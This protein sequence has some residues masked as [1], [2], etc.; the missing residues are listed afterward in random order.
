MGVR[1]E[2]LGAMLPFDG[3]ALPDSPAALADAIVRGLERYRISAREVRAE[4]G[5]WPSLD[6]LVVDLTGARISQEFRFPS[7]RSFG[8]EQIPIAHV[9]VRG[10]PI[11]FE[12]APL[13]LG[14]SAT[15]AALALSAA[16]GAGSLLTLA[17]VADGQI[18][19]EAQHHDLEALAHQ[20]IAP[21]A[22]QQGVE[23]QSTQVALTS[24]TP[25]SLDFRVE[26]SAKM[27]VMTARATVTGHVEVDDQFNAHLS[28][29]ACK[30]HGLVAGAATAFL[31]PH[32]A[33]LE[34]QPI[35]L[36]ALP[37]GEI[38]LRDVSVAVAG[39]VRLHARFGA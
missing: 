24:D 9:E 8:T 39:A 12:T 21:L 6:E 38:K 28:R 36:L 33:R 5:V 27:F 20:I 32:F 1:T 25:R 3:A 2:T 10:T 14:L 16:D 37:I 18:N 7:V 23:I 30:G 4:G 35:S 15:D 17:R 19:I 22:A 29:L 34:Q 31:R 26:I 11:Y 13:Q